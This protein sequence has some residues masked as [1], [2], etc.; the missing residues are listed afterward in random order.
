MALASGPGA[1]EARRMR[2]GLRRKPPT[3]PQPPNCPCGEHHDWLDRRPLDPCGYAH[4]LWSSRPGRI[5]PADATRL[6][7]TTAPTPLLT[8]PHD[9][10][11]RPETLI[12]PAGLHLRYDQADYHDDY[13]T[14][15]SQWDRF[16]V[17][18][19]EFA[20]CCVVIDGAID[21]PRLIYPAT[22]APVE[23]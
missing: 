20:G 17:L 6:W 12:L 21:P 9:N 2:F 19:G 14:Y 11:A 22:I 23:P 13:M 3:R 15:P 16:C 8:A 10:H 4:L 5:E 7:V 18:D 1:A